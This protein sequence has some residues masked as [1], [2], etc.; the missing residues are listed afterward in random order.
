MKSERS[1]CSK[2]VVDSSVVMFRQEGSRV[3][4]KVIQISMS[5]CMCCDSDCEVKR[6]YG[7]ESCC[8]E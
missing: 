8:A 6:V 3:E 2:S 5:I 1:W 4:Q 7:K